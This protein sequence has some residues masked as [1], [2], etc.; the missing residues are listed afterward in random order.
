VRITASKPSSIT[1]TM[2]SEKIHIQLDIRVGAHK[3]AEHR[4]QQAAYLRQADA[5]LAARRGAGVR[6]FLLGRLDLGQN[7]PR[8]LKKQRAFAG[9]GDTAR[10]AVKQ[11]DAQ[12]LFHARDTF[13][14]GPTTIPPARDRR[15]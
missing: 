12:A 6:Q 7:A 14:H 5:Q 15:R 1:S 9:Q 13:A 3:V 11:P 10:A 2:R 8:T 4:H